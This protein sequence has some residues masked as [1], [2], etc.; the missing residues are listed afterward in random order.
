MVCEITQLAVDFSWKTLVYQWSAALQN[1]PT[2]IDVSWYVVPT[3][4]K[5]IEIMLRFFKTQPQVVFKTR[6]STFK[7]LTVQDSQ[8]SF[9]SSGQRA[10]E[11]EKR[12]SA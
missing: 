2:K 3:E 12:R 9:E 5:K 10:I 11:Q 6:I 7:N 8:H 4:D 1:I